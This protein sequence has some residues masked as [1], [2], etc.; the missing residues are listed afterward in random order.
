MQGHK[1]SNA[2][3]CRTHSLLSQQCA[4]FGSHVFDMVGHQDSQ[5]ANPN[6]ANLIVDC[7]LFVIVV[8][9]ILAHTSFFVLFFLFVCSGVLVIMVIV[10]F[11]VALQAIRTIGIGGA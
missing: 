5:R 10:L 2:S 4:D 9:V 11:D 3:R 6:V 1:N 8:F 7:L